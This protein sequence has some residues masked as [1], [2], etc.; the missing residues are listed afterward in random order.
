MFIISCFFNKTTDKNKSP[1][2]SVVFEIS[3][4]L[5]HCDVLEMFFGLQNHLHRVRED[6]DLSYL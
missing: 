2:I 6:D 1:S 3:A 5:F 4:T